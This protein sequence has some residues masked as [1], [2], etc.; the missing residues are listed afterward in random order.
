[1]NPVILDQL[2]LSLA[3]AKFSLEREEVKRDPVLA[4][5]VQRKIESLNRTAS[6]LRLNLIRNCG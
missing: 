1:M 2:Q 6:T 4:A 5:K 3:F